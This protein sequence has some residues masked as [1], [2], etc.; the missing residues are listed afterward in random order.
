M[1]QQKKVETWAATSL[2]KEL[3]ARCFEAMMDA[4]DTSH[5]RMSKFRQ[6]VFLLTDLPYFC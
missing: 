4:D 1:I 2:L 6:F 5:A 3:S